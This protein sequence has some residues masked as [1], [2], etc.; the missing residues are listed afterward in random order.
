[1]FPSEDSGSVQSAAVASVGAMHS[2]IAFNRHQHLDCDTPHYV[3]LG[4]VLSLLS[5]AIFVRLPALV[6]LVFLTLICVGY[7][8]AIEIIDIAIF[9]QFDHY[10]PLKSVAS[11]TVSYTHLTLPTKRIV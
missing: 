1:M 6:K 5:V 10:S 4:A 3:Y 11:V 2:V 8:V 9:R 7:I